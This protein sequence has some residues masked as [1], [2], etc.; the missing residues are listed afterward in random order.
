MSWNRP[1]LDLT[2]NA[3][4]AAGTCW[5]AQAI[6]PHF[7]AC[8]ML[9]FW[10]KLSGI[11]GRKIHWNQIPRCCNTAT[12][13]MQTS[14]WKAAAGPVSSAWGS[15]ARSHWEHSW[16]SER[17]RSPGRA[18]GAPEGRGSKTP[19]V[20]VLTAHSPCWGTGAA[21]KDGKVPQGTKSLSQIFCWGCQ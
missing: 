6:S 20:A 17:A 21:S 15:W 18:G 12:T 7:S 8:G 13:D 9:W 3:E 1:L 19:R 10:P 5:A 4:P 14:G 11:W 2:W 16:V